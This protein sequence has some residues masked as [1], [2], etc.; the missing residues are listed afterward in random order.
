MKFIK[1][2]PVITVLAILIFIWIF[3][4]LIITLFEKNNPQ[5]FNKV[6]NS[7]WWTI[8]TMTTVG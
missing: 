8:V 4:S 3:G 2:N 5:G 7:L 6:E 1:K